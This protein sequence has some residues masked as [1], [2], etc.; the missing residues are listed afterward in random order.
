MPV[1]LPYKSSNILRNL[2]NNAYFCA[3]ILTEILKIC[4]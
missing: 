4:V 2:K 1:I 3:K